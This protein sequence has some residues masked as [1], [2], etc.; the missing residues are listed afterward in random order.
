MILTTIENKFQQLNSDD[1]K[2]LFENRKYGENET[3][4]Y[5]KEAFR[6]LNI[7]MEDCLR[8]YLEILDSEIKLPET[9]INNNNESNL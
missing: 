2:S 7:T 6:P 5:F 9:I 4:Y 8:D 1:G 3:P